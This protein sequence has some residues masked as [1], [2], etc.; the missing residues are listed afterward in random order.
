[1]TET[2]ATDAHA[3]GAFP[4]IAVIQRWP[5]FRPMLLRRNGIVDHRNEPAAADFSDFPG[6]YALKKAATPADSPSTNHSGQRPRNWTVAPSCNI[7]GLQHGGRAMTRTVDLARVRN[8]LKGKKLVGFRTETVRSKSA[9]VKVGK[10]KEGFTKSGKTP[11][12]KQPS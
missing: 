1:V 11:T 3:S 5:D 9:V 4:G 10:P 12:G 7:T 2:G 6:I 8:A